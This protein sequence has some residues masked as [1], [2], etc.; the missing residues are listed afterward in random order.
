[1]MQATKFK[2]SGVK[3]A[4]DKY[5]IETEIDVLAGVK[6]ITVDDQSGQAELEFDD[7][8]ISLV[9]IFSAVEKLGFRAIKGGSE[10]APK[11]EEHVYYIKGMHCASCEILIENRLLKEDG[12]KAVEASTSKCQVV[13]EYQGERPT[14]EKLNENFKSNDDTFF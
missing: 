2:I 8:K 6:D 9:N 5:S 11:I 14:I 3:S 7:S 10:T 13:V 4:N 1:M 12:I